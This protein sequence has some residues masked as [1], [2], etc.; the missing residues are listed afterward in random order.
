MDR[1]NHKDDKLESTNAKETPAE[2]I[3]DD[4]I[5][6]QAKVNEINE[7]LLN[8][9]TN[10]TRDPNNKPIDELNK[11]HFKVVKKIWL[12][13]IILSIINFWNIEKD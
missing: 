8:E 11:K 9:Y 3:T 2:N 5:H 13:Q 12:A 10:I 1:D 4:N 6:E 7:S